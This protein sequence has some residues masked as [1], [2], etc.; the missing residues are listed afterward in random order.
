MIGGRA[1]T[2]ECLHQS[3]ASEF[4]IAAYKMCAKICKVLKQC[5]KTSEV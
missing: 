4:E 5:S 2:S 1:D 3:S